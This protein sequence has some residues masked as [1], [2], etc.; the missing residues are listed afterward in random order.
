MEGHIT[1]AED[2]FPLGHLAQLLIPTPLLRPSPK[3]HKEEC[4]FWN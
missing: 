4:Y 1:A 3:N 2:N